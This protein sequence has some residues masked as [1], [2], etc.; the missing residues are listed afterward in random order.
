VVIGFAAI[1]TAALVPL[2]F[3]LSGYLLGFAHGAV[4]VFIVS[5]VGLLFLLNT[6]STRQLS[7]AFGEDNT[8][9]EL[10][11]AK[12]RGYIWGWIDN[13]E[14]QGGDVDHLVLAPSGVFAIDSKWHSVRV[15]DAVLRNDAA[16]ARAAAPA[17]DS[18]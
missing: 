16:A 11:R 17:P 3:V 10:R 18:F 1:G 2:S 9:D 12:R 7:G 14:V 15:D 5:A 13:V 6:G 4:A 8:R